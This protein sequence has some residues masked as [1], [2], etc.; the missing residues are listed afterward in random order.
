[1]GR[2]N[3]MVRPLIYDRGFFGES[4]IIAKHDLNI[5]NIICNQLTPADAFINTTWI[6]LDN[7]LIEI[8]ENTSGR[9]FCYSG[10]DWEN[11]KCRPAVHNLL[12][13]YNP[14]YVGNSSGDYYFSFWMDFVN[15]YLHKYQSFDPYDIKELKIFM[16][17][18]RKPHSHRIELVN[19][20]QKFCQLGFVSLGIETP[21]KLEVYIT[22]IEGDNA[23]HGDIGITN[24]I[25]S[26][27]HRQNWNSHF[28]NIVT[29]TT[30]HSD[31][32]LSEKIFKPIIGRRPF[33]VLGDNN[34]YNVLHSWGIDTFDDVFGVGYRNQWHTDRIS[35]IVNIIEDLKLENL[36]KLLISLKPRL[37]YNYRQFLTMSRCNSEKIN[38]LL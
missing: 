13:D 24:D 5:K 28:L 8:L 16:C 37:E 23:I 31:V 34:I 19:S 32:F 11:T 7:T 12:K 21:V 9:V 38:K 20:I 10:P 33:V 36:E 25:T 15:T 1:M 30:I 14:I 29:E 2:G 26:L 4:N 3:K 27:G 6:E 17:L 18:N 35:W 22:N